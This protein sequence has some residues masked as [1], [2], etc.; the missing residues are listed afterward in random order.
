VGE[1][2]HFVGC[3]AKFVQVELT[4]W[5]LRK[6]DILIARNF[7]NSH[8]WRWAKV[9]TNKEDSQSV[10]LTATEN[11]IL[12]RILYLYGLIFALRKKWSCRLHV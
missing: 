10:I 7:V 1:H 5:V 9:R 12:A 4:F 6:V 11:V 8:K 2:L 3:N